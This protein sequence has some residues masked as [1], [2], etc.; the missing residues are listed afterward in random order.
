MTVI[1]QRD[2]PCRRPWPARPGYTGA[3]RTLAVVLLAGWLG[4]AASCALAEE[5]PQHGRH[6][7]TA[8][9]S[10]DDAERWSRVFDAPDR[11]EWQKPAEVAAALQIGPGM[12]VADIGAGTGYFLEHLS[13]AA[14]SRGMVLAIDTEAEMVAHLGQ[15]MA[16]AGVTN[17]VPVLALPGDP[18]L[19]PGRV[20]RILI[21]DTYHHIDD[22]L[23]YFGRLRDAL[24]PA[25]R[26]AIIDFLKKPLPVGPPPEHKLER[27]FVLQEMIEAGW[28][29]ADEKKDLLPYQYF[30]IFEPVT[31]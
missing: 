21:V 11:A 23:R 4:A 6:D 19:P 7:A 5:P 27:E 25:G 18:F 9:H 20:D 2:E 13:R 31:E 24:A 17:V 14:G 30:L 8:T 15:R 10:F 3:P 26:L 16:G 22:R 1:A 29:L 12:V 28:K